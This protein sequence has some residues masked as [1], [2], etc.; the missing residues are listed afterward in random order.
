MK[1]ING[2]TGKGQGTQTLMF[3]EINKDY[4][5]VSTIKYVRSNF[6]YEDDAIE[7]DETMIF[8]S[9]ENGNANYNLPV[10]GQSPGDHDGVIGRLVSD[11]L[12]IYDFELEEEDSAN[13]FSSN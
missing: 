8:I 5:V 10:W 4:Y 12:T 3:D 2:D 13:S 7:Y 11:D 6:D 1:I 9:D